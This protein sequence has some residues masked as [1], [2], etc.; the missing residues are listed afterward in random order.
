[1]A[2][3]LHRTLQDWVNTNGRGAFVY[4]ALRVNCP[5]RATTSREPLGLDLELDSPADPV[6]DSITCKFGLTTTFLLMR[7]HQNGR[8]SCDTLRPG[9]PP[10]GER[11]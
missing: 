4:E 8:P 1:M 11:R 7:Y 2:H 10:N 6:V 9:V 5:A 3:V